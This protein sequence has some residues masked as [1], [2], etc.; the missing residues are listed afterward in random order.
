MKN[1]DRIAEFVAEF[2]E[3]KRVVTEDVKEIKGDIKALNEFRWKLG[4]ITALL[5]FL[6]TA[7]VELIRG[8][9]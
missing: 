1:L 4:G 7:A 9:K 2:R 8:M 6:V 5:C 3:F